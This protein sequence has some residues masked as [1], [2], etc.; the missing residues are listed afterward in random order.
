VVGGWS[1]VEKLGN[2]YLKYRL[3]KR[4]NKKA[5][6]NPCGAARLLNKIKQ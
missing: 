1:L 4:I 3:Q 5:E 6:Q 2:G